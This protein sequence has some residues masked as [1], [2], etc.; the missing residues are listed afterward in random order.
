MTV[1]AARIAVGVP[2]VALLALG[3]WRLGALYGATGKPAA[4]PAGVSVRV[5]VVRRGTLATTVTNIGTVQALNTVLVRA[6]V[7]GAIEEVLFKEGQIVSRGDVL[8]KLDPLPFEAQL[9]VNQ[10]QLAKDIASLDNA[11]VDLQRYEELLKADSTSTQ[12]RDTARSLVAEL[13]AAVANDAAQV[14]LARLSLSYTRIKAPI[15]GRVGA[16]LI[17]AGNIVHTADANGL[18]VITQL[19]PIAINFAVPQERLKDLRAAQ[20][21]GSIPVAV[22]NDAGDPSENTGEVVL[23]D[24]QIDTTTGTIHCK[25]Q[26]S[27]ASDTLWPGQFVTVRVALK[28]LPDAILIPT[29][30]VQNGSEGPYVYVVTPDNR[31]K[32]RVVHIGSVEGAQT[33]IASGL[34]AGETAVTEGQFRLEPD[35]LVHIV[36]VDSPRASLP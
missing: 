11:K 19:S 26:F 10:A 28:N 31:A 24:N 14:D 34:S 23:I 1:K 16:R 5:A 21:H 32:A 20:A 8:V 9:R 35:A 6:R 15:T 18:V 2:L 12:V 4:P 25:A 3:L 22:L 36:S 13:T 7:D 33:I 29:I 27:N 30:A 17:D